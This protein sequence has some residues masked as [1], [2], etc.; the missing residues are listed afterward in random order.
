MSLKDTIERL[1]SKID[2]IHQSID[3]DILQR[4]I[5]LTPEDLKLPEFD[6]SKIANKLE[7]FRDTLRKRRLRKQNKDNIFSQLIEIFDKV[8]SAGRSAAESERFVG[9]QRLRQ[10]V[11]DSAEITANSAK[12]IV[13]DCVKSA[14]FAGDGICGGNSLFFG[15]DFDK[16]NIKP[17]EIDFLNMLRVDP[18]SDYGKLMYEKENVVNNK[19]KVNL[20]LYSAFT[21][22]TYPSKG[23]PGNTSGYTYQYNTPS[24]KT[25]FT[26]TWDSTGQ[27]FTISGLTQSTGITVNQFLDDYYSNMEWPDINHILRNVMLLTIKA[28]NVSAN[29]KGVSIG[30]SL[31]GMEDPLSWSPELDDAINYLERMLNK[32]FAFCN[33]RGRMLSGQTATELLNENEEDDEFYFDFDDVEGIDLEEEDARKRKVLKF[34]D[35]NNFEVPY[36]ATIM[37]DFIYLEDKLNRND[38]VRKTLD[39]S[40][41]DAYEQSDFSIELPDYQ[42]SINLGFILNIP[43]AIVMSIISPKMFLPIVTIYKLFTPNITIDTNITAAEIMKR[44]KK[45]FKCVITELFWK[46]LRELWKK[47]K[48]DLKNFLQRI[49]RRILREKLKRYYIVVMA[50]ISLLKKIIENGL[51][52]CADLFAAI[53]AAIDGALDSSGVG[54]LPNALL[55]MADKLPGFSAIKTHMES[56]EKMKASGVFTGDVN[57]EPNYLMAAFLAN[58][59]SMADNIAKTPFISTNKGMVGSSALGPVYIPPGQTQ[60]AALMK[61]K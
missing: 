11:I 54:S 13:M 48:A 33:N 8:L 38:W 16:V 49:I 5:E 1:K 51:D 10:H 52:N 18:E 23:V 44:L 4:K 25:L 39:K 28:A 61:T 32:L 20:G 26:S 9:N 24:N 45:L 22:G 36:N 34:K 40:A 14:L 29:K 3:S 46:F 35:C 7:Q 15:I 53:G 56:V 6:T 31:S 57:G 43:K 37:E 17:K 30:T 41:M 12:T 42:L 21:D 60:Q 59:T 2:I 58:T 27:T 50:L 47:L 19:E 55:L